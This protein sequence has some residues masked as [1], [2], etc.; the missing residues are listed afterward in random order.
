MKK[1]EEL[2]SILMPD[3]EISVSL[4]SGKAAD[5][6]TCH[7]KFSLWKGPVVDFDYGG[8]PL[9]DYNDE[10]IF[11]ELAILRVLLEDGW[12]GAWVETYGGI[13]FLREMPNSWKLLSHSIDIPQEKREIISQIQKTA[14]TSACFDVFAWKGS[15]ILF[16]EAKNKGKD[17][18]TIGQL[19]FIEG[20]LSC[21]ISSESLLIAEWEMV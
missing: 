11:A 18:L 7:P 14:K 5:L 9:I 10:P 19:K 20:A 12:N 16:C 15:R 3:G 6:P 8:K 17:K 4:P 13:H 1:D 21:G 2:P